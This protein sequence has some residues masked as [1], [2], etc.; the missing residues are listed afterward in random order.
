MLVLA[1]VLEKVQRTIQVQV[2]AQVQKLEREAQLEARNACERNDSHMELLILLFQC[3]FRDKTWVS[4]GI[5]GPHTPL[6][7]DAVGH[8]LCGHLRELLAESDRSI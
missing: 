4:E 1:I 2:D 5:F 6:L 7:R 8:K 3:K